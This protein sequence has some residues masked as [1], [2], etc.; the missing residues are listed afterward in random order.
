MNILNSIG[1]DNYLKNNYSELRDEIKKEKNSYIKNIDKIEIIKNADILID[2]IYKYNINHVVVTNTSSDNV[3]FFKN[4]IPILSKLNNWITREDYIN[5]KPDSEC[6][7]L[8]KNKFYKN[9][10]YIIGI[11]NSIAGYLSIKNLTESIYI[12]TDKNKEDYTYFK[13][14]N[15]YLINDYISIFE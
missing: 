3:N 4:K 5:P 7:N 10:K 2:Y 15:V 1:I 14:E 8:A 13:K 9:E 6:Y 11:E 12:I